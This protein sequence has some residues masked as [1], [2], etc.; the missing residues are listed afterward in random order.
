MSTWGSHRSNRGVHDESSVELGDAY[1]L[2]VLFPLERVPVYCWSLYNLCL[3][4]HMDTIL[5]VY[6]LA[7]SCHFQD[8]MNLIQLNTSKKRN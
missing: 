2:G 5:T 6:Q 8:V 3:F 1:G 7:N 4:Q